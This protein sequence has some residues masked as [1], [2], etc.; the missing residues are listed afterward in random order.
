MSKIWRWIAPVAVA[1][2]IVAGPVVVSTAIPAQAASQ[3]GYN[4]TIGA[5]GTAFGSVKGKVDGKALVAY[6]AAGHSQ[7]TISGTVTGNLAGDIVSLLA[8][9]FRA[10]S[11]RPTGQ[12]VT[13]AAAGSGR[14][15]FAVRPSLVTS[16]EV[17][18]STTGTAGTGVDA[19]SAPAA[20]YVEASGHGFKPHQKCSATQCRYWYTA[21]TILP[22]SAYRTESR[23]HV[24]MYLAQWYSAKHPAKWFYPARTA[25]TSKVKR[26]SSGEFE[27]TYTWPVHLRTG[28]N[29]WVPLSCTRDS[30]TKDGLGLPGQHG[31]GA[32]R[33]S[34]KTTYLG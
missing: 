20:V 2:T 31:C 3:A 12:Q 32:T 24:Y 14:Y 29:Y 17:R 15:S 22:A 11:F 18:V 34:T 28:Q 26:I 30:V 6:K 1:G 33:V 13:L 23:K 19:T 5:R 27:L 7:G 4:V 16:Y 9:P 10:T 8:R 21:S 25:R